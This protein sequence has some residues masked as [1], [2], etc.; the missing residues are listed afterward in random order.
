[1]EV[2]GSM[3]FASSRAESPGFHM[4]INDL[5]SDS[6]GDQ[7][8][9]DLLEGKSSSL[10]EREFDTE[11][12][13]WQSC[14]LLSASPA[15]VGGDSET[16]KFRHPFAKMHVVMGHI[17]RTELEIERKYQEGQ[18]AAFDLFLSSRAL[19]EGALAEKQD[20]LL[21]GLRNSHHQ[22]Y[23]KQRGK[24][25]ALEASLRE[26]EMKRQEEEEAARR[27]EE[28]RR[29]CELARREAQ[30]AAAL[31]EKRKKEVMEEIQRKEEEK[32]RVQEQ[33]AA[34]V[35]REEKEA[36]ARMISKGAIEYKQKFESSLKAF[37]EQTADFVSDRSMKDAQRG[38]KKF[39]TLAV[40]QI[41]ATQEQV[42]KKSSSLAHFISQQHDVQKKFSILTLAG[43][44]MS[45][46]DVQIT[47]L[48]SF[49]FPLAQVAV[50]V[51]HHHPELLG[52]ITGML[53]RDCPLSVPALYVK[54]E[55]E[56]ELKYFKAM[57][58]KIDDSGS[59]AKVEADDEYVDRL[60][61]YVRFYAALLQ[62]DNAV[63]NFNISTAWI[64]LAW[65]LNAIPASRY[66]ASALDAFLS[67]A[68]YK[69]WLTF[70]TQFV[71]LLRYIQDIFL[72]E[73]KDGNDPDAR[74]VATR[75]QSYIQMEM[76]MRMPEGRSMPM[77]DESSYNRA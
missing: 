12:F 52:I 36:R 29:K 5:S 34:L 13:A 18:K 41:S 50:S 27:E 43:K 30:K 15:D 49:A 25:A 42:N 7:E 32:L 22:S 71:K 10:Y 1:M 2:P 19:A 77:R 14:N 76:Y 6:D 73:L 26:R 23:L 37:T 9:M 65:L 46:C 63:D 16:S 74:A 35:K 33:Q 72:K 39:I 55:I 20:K 57:C 28:E 68:G 8:E 48:P 54:K 75:V 56:P 3:T 64:Y 24:V 51:G 11:Q 59:Y 47:R 45:Q 60:Q 66:S 31:E 69:L 38:I 62:S 53:H 4:E 67:V 44:L 21:E 17:D 40:Q 70:K 61:G 58:F